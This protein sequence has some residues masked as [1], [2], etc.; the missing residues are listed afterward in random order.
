MATTYEFVV[1][2]LDWYEG[3]GDD[4]DIIETVPHETLGAAVDYAQTCEEPWRITLRR[5]TGSDMEGLISRYYAYP[6]ESGML[7]SCMGSCMGFDDGPAVPDK[8]RRMT[9]PLD[10]RFR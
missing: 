2:T 10:K 9:I 6:D 7:P 3:C 5:D 4:P 1:E 8:Y